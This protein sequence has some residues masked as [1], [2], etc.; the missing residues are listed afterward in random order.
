ML[1]NLLISAAVGPKVACDNMREACMGVG[2]MTSEVVVTGSLFPHAV[3]RID[4]KRLA[5]ILVA[6]FFN[7]DMVVISLMTR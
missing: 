3:T 7:V 6:L 4:K 1:L 2:V 5:E